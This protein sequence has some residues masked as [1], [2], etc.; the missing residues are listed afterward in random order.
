MGSGRPSGCLHIQRGR[1]CPFLAPPES[2][3]LQMFKEASPA[4]ALGCGIDHGQEAKGEILGSS[5]IVVALA[6]QNSV[7]KPWAHRTAGILR[8][9]T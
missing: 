6:S 1:G 4:E 5:P 7:R 3:G 9:A 8:S 2:L